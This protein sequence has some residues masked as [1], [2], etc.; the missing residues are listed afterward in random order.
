MLVLDLPEG[1]LA[2]ILAFYAI[3]NL[4]RDHLSA[5]FREMSRVLAPSGLLLLAFRVGDELIHRDE[6]WGKPLSLDFFFYEPLLIM[7]LLRDA[8][9]SIEEQVVR[10]PYPPQVEYQSRRSYISAI[11]SGH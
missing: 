11:K 4:P 10:E 1:K 5:V 7:R 6:M 9:F 2:R 3:C 8:G